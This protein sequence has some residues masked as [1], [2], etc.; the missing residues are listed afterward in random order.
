MK[1]DFTPAIASEVLEQIVPMDIL[2]MVRGSDQKSNIKKKLAFD[3]TF[4][5]ITADHLML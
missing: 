1:L 5:E 2:V 3:Y 4:M